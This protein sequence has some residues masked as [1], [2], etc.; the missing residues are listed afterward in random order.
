MAF[1]VEA[2]LVDFLGDTEHFPCHAGHK[3]GDKV[4]YDGSE[5]TG[6]MCTDLMLPLV[7]EIIKVHK[8]G[9]R[10]KQP[11]YYNLFWHSVNS[12]E[13]TSRAKYD[14]NG[15]VPINEP[16]DLPKHHVADLN[17]K[18][19]F[20]WPPTDERVACSDV[21]VMCKDLRTA[22]VFKVEAV[23]FATAGYHL[24]YTRRMMTI[25]DRVV[26][27]G[28]SCPLNKVLDLYD[29]FERNEIYPTLVQP[30]VNEMSEEM[31]LIGFAKVEDGVL[32]ITD[33]GAERVK[34]YAT[35]IPEEHAKALKLI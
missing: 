31:E 26:K 9:P 17:P 19:G 18:G 25:M 1:S 20:C 27:N 5:L 28:G 33:K 23:D 29:D 12:Y 15:F 14:G 13:D 10:Y 35:E 3:V 7:D 34:K 32:T 8:M 21:M 30:M 16:F 11:D 6:K 4:Y 22:A 2:T 24:P